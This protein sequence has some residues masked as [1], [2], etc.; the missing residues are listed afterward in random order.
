MA[1]ITFTAAVATALLFA[2][3]AGTAAVSTDQ[4]HHY[5]PYNS[6]RHHASLPPLW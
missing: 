1:K 5:R 6:T 2:L 4:Q 3:A